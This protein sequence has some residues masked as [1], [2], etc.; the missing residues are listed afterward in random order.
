MFGSLTA[1]VIAADT[2]GSRA[3]GPDQNFRKFFRKFACPA[4]FAC[5][6][7]PRKFAGPADPPQPRMRAFWGPDPCGDVL[8]RVSQKRAGG[9]FALSVDVA[10]FPST[11]A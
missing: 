3:F 6:K 8:V 4:D 11:F 10:T 7:F 2:S 1:D 5:R 9:S